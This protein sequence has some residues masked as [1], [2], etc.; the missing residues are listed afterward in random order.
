MLE[1]EN[2]LCVQLLGRRMTTYTQ[3]TIYNNEM[4]LFDEIQFYI[5]QD[6]RLLADPGFVRGGGRNL[7]RDF[8]GVAKQSC[9]SE[10]VNIGRD[11]GPT[12]GPWK[13][14]HS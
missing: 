8:A 12:L 11:P 2:H 13:L 7:F 14:L 9:G 5:C 10:G 1:S 6:W 4:L 3:K